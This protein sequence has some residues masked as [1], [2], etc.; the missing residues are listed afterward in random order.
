MEEDK[1][2]WSVTDPL[3]NEVILKESTFQEHIR[4]D[5]KFSDSEYRQKAELKASETIKNPQMIIVN[6]EKSNRHV[7]YKIVTMPC[8]EDR[9]SLK[10]MKIVVDTDRKPNQIVTWILQSKLKDTIKEGWLEYAS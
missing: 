6:K 3:G 5:H 10:I 2:R 9:E 7:Y 8:D 4:K 1:I